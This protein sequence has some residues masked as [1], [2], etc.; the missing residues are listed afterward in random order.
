MQLDELPTELIQK[1]IKHNVIQDINKLRQTN[2]TIY[3]KI[4]KIPYLTFSAY[5]SSKEPHKTLFDVVTGSKSYSQFTM[6][7]RMKLDIS[8]A[9]LTVIRILIINNHSDEFLRLYNIKKIQLEKLTNDVKKEL[10]MHS[11]K[12][13]HSVKIIT[14]LLRYTNIDP[15]DYKNIIKYSLR[16]NDHDLIKLVFNICKYNENTDEITD[17]HYILYKSTKSFLKFININEFWDWICGNNME[18]VLSDFKTFKL[19]YGRLNLISEDFNAINKINE[20]IFKQACEYKKIRIIEFFIKRFGTYQNSKDKK[21]IN[22]MISNGMSIAINNTYKISRDIDDCIYLV[23]FLLMAGANIHYNHDKALLT[24][25]KHN[26]IQ[27]VIFLLKKGANIHAKSDMALNM[28]IGFKVSMEMIE[29]LFKYGADAKAKNSRVLFTALRRYHDIRLIILLL[30]HN[31][32]VNAKGKVIHVLLH[33]YEN[34]GDSYMI[35][36]LLLDYNVKIDIDILSM[37]NSTDRINTETKN[38]ILLD[39]INHIC[40]SDYLLIKK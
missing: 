22:D 32:D 15:F 14:I 3:N 30:S 8:Y 39:I 37:V 40:Y 21:K 11:I 33:Y 7:H 18:S 31:I 17:C 38:K 10:L 2:K 27:I 35:L 12:C 4:P 26:N 28:A 20:Y 1:I 23:K 16:S 29:L 24:A 9:S 36:Q 19:I 34:C 25:I 13:M 5:N 6:Y